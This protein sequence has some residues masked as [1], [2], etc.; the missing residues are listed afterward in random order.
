LD[1]LE[2]FLDEHLS[3]PVAFR[4]PILAENVR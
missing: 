1:L 3:I 4:M 2:H